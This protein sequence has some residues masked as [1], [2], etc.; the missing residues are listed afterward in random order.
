MEGFWRCF[1]EMEA[2]LESMDLPQP[3]LDK[4]RR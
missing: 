1:Q 4:R 2:A 3:P